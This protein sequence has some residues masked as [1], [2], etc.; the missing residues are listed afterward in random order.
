MGQGRRGLSSCAILSGLMEAGSSSRPCDV[1]SGP[2]GP[3]CSDASGCY[4]LV[5]P[6]MF[7]TSSDQPRLR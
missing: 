7:P 2:V 1:S 3:L 6:S 5:A 4:A